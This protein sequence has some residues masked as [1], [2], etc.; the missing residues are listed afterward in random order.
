MT[1]RVHGG[2]CGGTFCEYCGCCEHGE[3]TDGIGC[4]ASDAPAGMT[5][6]GYYCGC[7]GT[8]GYKAPTMPPEADA[9]P[10]EPSTPPQ[11]HQELSLFDVV[12]S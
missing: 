6:P 10:V 7:E 3:A 9:D 11:M 8:M 1:T 2:D 12:P 5:C 4:R